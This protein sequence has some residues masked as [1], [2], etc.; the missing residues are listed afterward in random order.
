MHWGP[1]SRTAQLLGWID[2]TPQVAARVALL[3]TSLRRLGG[4]P[5]EA[6]PQ[7]RRTIPA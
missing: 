4:T 6:V 7:T 3:T 1:S 5:Q 2:V